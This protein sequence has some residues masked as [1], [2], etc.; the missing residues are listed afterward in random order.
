MCIAEEQSLTGCQRNSLEL[1]QSCE[2]RDKSLAIC[3]ADHSIAAQV[4]YAGM[5]ALV[6][7][8]VLSCMRPTGFQ[9]VQGGRPGC[10]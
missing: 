2:A 8:G 7:N 9:R 4:M 5:K 1:I 6:K 3:S 10:W